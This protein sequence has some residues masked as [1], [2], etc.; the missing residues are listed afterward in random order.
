MVVL[1]G[2]MNAC[3]VVKKQLSDFSVVLSGSGAGGLGVASLL[4]EA[5]VTK[6]S[7]LDSKGIIALGREGM[8]VY[9]DTF[10]KQINP[11]A[12]TGTLADA[13]ADLVEQPTADKIIPSPFDSGMTQAVAQAVMNAS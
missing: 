5:G 7:I 6:M 11:E 13:L 10:A 9:K 12:K 3:K 2:L 4:L 1:A 8:N